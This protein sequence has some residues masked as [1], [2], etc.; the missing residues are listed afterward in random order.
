MFLMPV[1]IGIP[2][3]MIHY[4][5]EWFTQLIVNIYRNDWSCDVTIRVTDILHM[6][7]GWSATSGSKLAGGG[8]EV[9]LLSL[10]NYPGVERSRYDVFCFLW[11]DRVNI[12]SLVPQLS[13]VTNDYWSWPLTLSG[14]QGGPYHR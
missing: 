10:T 11:T 13:L 7:V 3:P 5:P 4:I 14:L 12:L 6:M 2:D 1:L 9:F 8:G